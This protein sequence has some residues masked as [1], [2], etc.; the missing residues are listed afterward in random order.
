MPNKKEPLSI[1]TVKTLLAVIIFTGV[2]TI[3]VGGGWLIGKQGKV[4]ESVKPIQQQHIKKEVT[5]ATDKTEYEQWETVRITVNNNLSKLIKHLNGI[6]CGVQFFCNG[7]WDELSGGS[8]A[9]N[10][11]NELLKSNSEYNFD[12]VAYSIT[13]EP[14]KYRIAFYYQE[15]EFIKTKEIGKIMCE[16]EFPKELE[17]LLLNGKWIKNN[18]NSCCGCMAKNL[19]SIDEISIDMYKTSG[20]CDRTTYI[21]K[22][23]NKEYNCVAENSKL[24]FGEYYFP[25]R[26]WDVVYSNEFTIEGKPALDPRCTE[27][28]IVGGLNYDNIY[29]SFSLK[30]GKCFTFSGGGRYKWETPFKTLEE[31]QEVCEKKESNIP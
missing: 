18:V 4:S 15:L 25:P 26:N 13:P 16:E 9:W 28:K 21:I 3:I 5:I 10:G 24:L 8:C 30:T 7:K 20:S 29:H 6:G 12:W 2:G 22:Y 1:M 17:E 19:W 23:Q 11:G 27:Q 31:C 14:E